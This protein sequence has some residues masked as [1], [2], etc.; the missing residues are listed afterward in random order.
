MTPES[1]SSAAGKRSFFSAAGHFSEQS[2]LSGLIIAMKEKWRIYPLPQK[3]VN[4]K[5]VF[6]GKGE[7]LCPHPISLSVAALFC[8]VEKV[9]KPGNN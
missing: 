1:S 6:K 5:I 4:K 2:R 7:K 3:K 9:K 8:A